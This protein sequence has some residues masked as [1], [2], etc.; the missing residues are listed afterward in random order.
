MENHHSISSILRNL[1][2]AL[3]DAVL[4]S[5]LSNADVCK[6]DT[7]FCSK[8]MRS[9]FLNLLKSGIIFLHTP[10]LTKIEEICSWV[11]WV[12]QRKVCIGSCHLSSAVPPDLYMRFFA[13]A[14]KKLKRVAIF[15]NHEIDTRS[16]YCSMIAT[17][18][19]YCT[20]ITEIQLQNGACLGSLENLLYTNQGSL[21]VINLMNCDLSELKI[22]NIHLPYLKRLF[23]ESYAGVSETVVSR[24]LQAAPNL[25]ILICESLSTFLP[26]LRMPK[27]LRVL[28]LLNSQQLTDAMFYNIAHTCAQLELVA[29]C[30]CPLL[31]DASLVE[32]ALHAKRLSVLYLGANTNF[33]DAALEAIAVHCGEHLK[34]VGINGCGRITN[35]GF[36]RINE[37]CH[38][39]EGMHIGLMEQISTAAVASVL[40]VNPLLREV[41]LGSYS[42]EEGDVLL[43]VISTCCPLLEYLDL[44]ELKGYTEAG[45]FAVIEA[46]PQLRTLVVDPD[47]PVITPE[48]RLQW[49]QQRPGFKIR[50]ILAMAPVLE[51]YVLELDLDAEILEESEEED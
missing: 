13:S 33:S 6:L 19:C 37:R 34:H 10:K 16:E 30:S 22:R 28:I 46:C 45:V 24:F 23:L 1:P 35:A 14:C 26:G 8:E 41:T 18:A 7:A 40:R 3:Q 20:N 49:E 39:L 51:Q 43:T 21:T 29:F 5:W 2:L 9:N 4:G 32:L 25:E 15:S 17:I 47:N 31:T 38:Q 12:V 44:Y 11:A 42:E 50:L 27:T 48:S 36:N